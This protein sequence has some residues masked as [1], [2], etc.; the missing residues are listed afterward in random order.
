[1]SR[2]DRLAELSTPK[3]NRIF[4]HYPAHIFAQH[5]DGTLDLWVSHAYAPAD[6]TTETEA[7]KI[8]REHHHANIRYH[9]QQFGEDMIS[10]CL[11]SSEVTFS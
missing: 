10:I 2:A 3:V 4:E 7:A 11:P 1:M 9:R 6:L 5:A 8:E